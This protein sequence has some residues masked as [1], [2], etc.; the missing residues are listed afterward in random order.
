M[1]NV[2][3]ERILFTVDVYP[4]GSLKLA[5]MQDA[6]LCILRNGERV[7][8]QQWRSEQID[9]SVMAYERLRHQLRTVIPAEAD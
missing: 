6:S 7:V 3:I 8:G 5:E 9:Q 1:A 2:A 4:G